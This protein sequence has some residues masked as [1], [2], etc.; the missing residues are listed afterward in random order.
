MFKTS[1][2]QFCCIFAFPVLFCSLSSLASPPSAREYI[3]IYNAKKGLFLRDHQGARDAVKAMYQDVAIKEFDGSLSKFFTETM[4]TFTEYKKKRV[5][6]WLGAKRFLDHFVFSSSGQCVEALA[7]FMIEKTP[8]IIEALQKGEEKHEDPLVQKTIQSVMS[9]LQRRNRIDEMIGIAKLAEL[10]AQADSSSLPLVATSVSSA[11]LAVLVYF[12][13]PAA[14]MIGVEKTFPLIYPLVTGKAV[15]AAGSFAYY[16]MY[17]PALKNAMGYSFQYSNQ[18]L[19]GLWW[20]GTGLAYGSYKSAH[21]LTSNLAHGLMVR[22]YYKLAKAN[23]CSSGNP[24]E[25]EFCEGA[26][27]FATEEDKQLV[28]LLDAIETEDGWMLL[29]PASAG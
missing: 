23:S 29:Q 18:I 1:W 24:Q 7:E 2:K 12:Y 6:K 5:A 27:D 28:R 20:G 19:W 3:K 4:G 11:S 10:V 13:G 22:A 17:L 16:S 8:Q 9:D 15:P 21:W 25:A 14:L 26:L